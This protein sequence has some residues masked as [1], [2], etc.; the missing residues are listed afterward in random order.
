MALG[1][2]AKETTSR[3]CS[4]SGSV[5]PCCRD[6]SRRRVAAGQYPLAFFVVDSFA[7]TFILAGL[8]FAVRVMD[9]GGWEDYVGFGEHK[10]ISHDRGK[11]A[12]A[13]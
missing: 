5:G 3:S 11:D 10:G 8:Y 2:W 1:N 6:G 4:R 12:E 13:W 9:R 7:N